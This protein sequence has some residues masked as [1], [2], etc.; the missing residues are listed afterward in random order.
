MVKNIIW[1]YER[2]HWK[3]WVIPIFAVVTCIT[4]IQEIHSNNN[5][6]TIFRYSSL[7]LL[8]HQPLYIAYPAS[9]EDYF[10]YHPSFTVLFMPFAFLPSAV[11]LCAWTI[12]STVVF[13]RAVYLLPGITDTAKKI[14]LLLVFPELINNQQYVQTNIFL[15][16]LMLLAFIYFERERLAWAAFFTL[17]A[18]CIKGYGGI[19]GLLFLLYPDKLKFLIYAFLWGI[20]IS[21][22]PLLFVSFGETIILYTDWLKII[23]S[24]E[25]K[26]GMSIIGISGKTHQS[27][28]YITIA[29]FLLLCIS[30]LVVF[31]YRNQFYFRGLLYCYLFLW[32]VLFNR[33]AESPT[34]QLAVTGVAY[35]F[36]LDGYKRKHFYFISALLL[37]VYL[38][39]SDLFPAVFHRFFKQYHL[40]VYPF[41]LYFLYLQFQTFYNARKSTSLAAH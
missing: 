3:K 4:C 16:A 6:I 24:D 25:I 20:V 7:H 13:V 31:R 17:L 37:Y 33:A 14:I 41:I 32:V 23:S 36:V 39:P 21:A 2:G 9:Y 35:W 30:F 40:K 5:N 19:V 29:G 27:E 8:A 15:A 38:L 12:L 22:L 28:L 1:L 26:E 10:L 18:F 34:Y 11:A